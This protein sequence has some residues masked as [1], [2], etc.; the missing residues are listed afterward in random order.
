LNIYQDTQYNDTQH[1]DIYHNATKH[2][3][4]NATLSINDTKITRPSAPNVAMLNVIYAE[5]RCA[6]YLYAKC[7]NVEDYL[8]RYAKYHHAECRNA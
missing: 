7:H 3:N 6:D 5:C 2:N 8:C 4:K 1:Y